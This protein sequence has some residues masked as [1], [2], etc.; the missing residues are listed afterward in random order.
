MR[1]SRGEK[2]PGCLFLAL[3]RGDFLIGAWENRG[4]NANANVDVHL[5]PDERYLPRWI[6]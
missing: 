5:V 1:A 3:S 6:K 2:P 4:A